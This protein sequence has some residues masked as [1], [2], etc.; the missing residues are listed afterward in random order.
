MGLLLKIV[1]A[2]K[3]PSANEPTTDNQLL[4]DDIV[5]ATD[6]L[7]SIVERIYNESGRIERA[8]GNVLT[9]SESILRNQTEALDGV[10]TLTHFLQTVQHRAED[11]SAQAKIMRETNA[12]LKEDLLYTTNS[13]NHTSE[14]FASLI[15]NTQ[16]A[17]QSI[18]FLLEQ[19]KPITELQKMLQTLVEQ[20]ATLAMNASIEA[21]YAGAGCRTLA[22]VES[23]IKELADQGKRNLLD[24]DPLLHSIQDASQEALTVLDKN[25]SLIAANKQE[26]EDSYRFLGQVQG[27]FDVLEQIISENEQSCLKQVETVQNMTGQL[28]H[29]LNKSKESTQLATDVQSIS[30]SQNNIVRQL[31]EASKHLTDISD[32]FSVVVKQHSDPAEIIDNPQFTIDTFAQWKGKMEA[33]ASQEDLLRSTPDTLQ[34]IFQAWMDETAALEAVWLNNADGDFLHSLPP[35][36]ILNAKRRQWFTGALQDGFYIS[37]PYISAITKRPCVTISTY[38]VDKDGNSGVLGA[39]IHCN[40]IEE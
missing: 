17:T 34:D 40:V 9:M 21:S 4:T 14:T 15:E 2:Y 31:L 1:N 8:S 12:S 38:L 5:V 23:R 6:R 26:L 16:R 27:R 35:A 18:H 32:A 37:A 10:E 36:G 28:T 19:M 30:A 25:Q 20:T 13:L 33:W 39:D 24:I 29:L 7:E 3:N 22:T 11:T